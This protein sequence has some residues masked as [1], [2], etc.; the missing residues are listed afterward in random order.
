MDDRRALMAACIANPEEDTPRLALADWLQEHGDE[1][2]CARAE[3]I[4]LQIRAESLPENSASRK[5]LNAAAEELESKH[6]AHWLA[7]LKQFDGLPSGTDH[8]N[9][10]FT[11]GFLHFLNFRPTEF[12][13]KDVQQFLPDA[14]AQVGVEYLGLFDNRKRVDAK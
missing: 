9:S 4:R 13:R 7:P 2:D 14:L 6:R 11:R 3:F 1:H 10:G 12:L 8:R 5:K